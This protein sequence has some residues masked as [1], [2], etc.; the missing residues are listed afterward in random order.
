MQILQANG[1]WG[2]YS[3]SDGFKVAHCE[4]TLEQEAKKTPQA[5]IFRLLNQGKEELAEYFFEKY[6]ATA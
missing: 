5:V 3:W 6:V 4:P 2:G 1:H